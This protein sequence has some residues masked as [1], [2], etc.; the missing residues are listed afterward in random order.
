MRALTFHGRE[1]IRCES[2]PD[3][4]LQAPTDVIVKVHLAGLCG[5]DLHIY[6]G[7]EKGLDPGTVMGH[8]FV[9]E[10]A[11]VGREVEKFKRGD[12]VLA[13]F[14]TNCGKCFYCHRGLTARCPHGQLFGWVQNGAGLQG[15]QAEFVRVPLADATLLKMPAEALPEEA[16]LLGDA[17]S[18]G[19]FCAEMAQLDPRATCAVIGCGPV[20]LMAIL[21]A[22]HLGAERI[23]AIDAIPERL[24]LAQDFGA[25]PVNFHQENPVDIVRAVTEGRGA[26]AVLEIVGNES[27][28][29]LA[30][31]LVRPGGIIAAAGVHHEA[32]FAF[33]PAEAY[34]KNLTYRTGRCS[35]RYYAGRLLSLL[36]QRK[37]ELA[38]LIS[39]RLPLAQGAQAY[40][41]FAEKQDG[42]IKVILQ[43]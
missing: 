14:T 15:G 7:R 11:E 43:P 20:G 6:H 38:R 25:I 22:R 41:I 40:Q 29:R 23:Y 4:A 13:P 10:I 1:D 33:T 9:G 5:S 39:H 21:A 27:A 32:Q 8:E 16:L 18:T 36:Q 26:D 31:A 35:A 30:M 12:R 2:L 19:Y 24:A 42:C 34:D 17:F 28:L 37:H 3:P